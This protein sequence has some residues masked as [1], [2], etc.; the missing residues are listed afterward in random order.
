MQVNLF[1]YQVAIIALSGVLI[2]GFAYYLLKNDIDRYL[3]IKSAALNL[4][5]GESLMPLRLQAHERLIL[6]IE[7]INPANLLV[8]L[9][10]KGIS[11]ADLQ[12]IILNEINLEYQ[13]NITQQ[14]YISSTTWNV[15]RKLKEDTISMISN[16]ASG[17]PENAAGID[18][19]KKVLQHMV[20][21]ENNPYD[22]T[23]DLI[24][25]D[26]HLKF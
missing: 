19:S 1:L 10:Q 16:A 2:V 23:L 17:L 15:V 11:V 24:K 21:M 6:F 13:H 4:N 14:L 3:K 25:K 7:R 9:H 20:T 22:L 8:R 26:I 5:T 12:S 18:L